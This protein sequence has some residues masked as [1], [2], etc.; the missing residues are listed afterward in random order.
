MTD[1]VDPVS[2]SPG[3]PPRSVGRAMAA[4]D[5]TSQVLV[6]AGLAAVVIAILGIP[7]GAWA[8]GTFSVL[9]IVAGLAAAGVAWLRGSGALRPMVLPSRD[10]ELAAAAVVGVLAIWNLIEAAFDLDQIGDERGGIV[11]LLLT[12][13]LAVAGI[14]LLGGAARRWSSGPMATLRANMGAAL[15]LAGVALVLLGWTL[16]LSVS[17]WTMTQATVTLALVAV[18]GALVVAANDT[19]GGLRM[20]LAAGA[21]VVGLVM[22][23]LALGQWGDLARLGENRIDLSLTDIGAFLIYAMGVVALIGGS[24]LSAVATSKTGTADS[25]G[26]ASV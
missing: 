24:V 2:A 10:L 13:L 7:L 14:V 3:A 1:P 8:L 20:G 25:P 17:Y 5:T 18:A 15:A 6:G 21:A 23:V 26:S 19:N 22:A 11:G 12:I 16:N 9:V 4:L